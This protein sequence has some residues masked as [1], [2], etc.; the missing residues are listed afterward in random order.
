MTHP[1]DLIK[2]DPRKKISKSLSGGA[3]FQTARSD[4]NPGRKRRSVPAG[5]SKRISSKTTENHL[6]EKR[7][8]GLDVIEEIP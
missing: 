8:G 2:K 3:P 4:Q 6:R 7:A 1:A 5:R